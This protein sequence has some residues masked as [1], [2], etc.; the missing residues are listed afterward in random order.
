M[1]DKVASKEVFLCG[2]ISPLP[3]HV[4]PPVISFQSLRNVAKPQTKYESRKGQVQHVSD[5]D[6]GMT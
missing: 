5:S 4:L 6:L 3:G 1:S 2:T